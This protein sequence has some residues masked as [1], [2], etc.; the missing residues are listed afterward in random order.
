[1]AKGSAMTT[2]AQPRS[3]SSANA[4]PGRRRLLR[5]GAVAGA[6]AAAG[7]VWVL[8]VPVAGV[9]LAVRMGEQVQDVGLGAIVGTALA[10][11]LLGW[12]LLAVLESRSRR[13]V[14][15]WTAVALAVLVL[16]LAGPLTSAV[17]G[18]AA[19]VLVALHLA[20]AGML[21]PALRRTARVR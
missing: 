14:G 15:V 1:M 21:I 4:G 2:T 3:S 8:A 20:V 17:T 7:L 9:D 12:A 5:A 19:A 6:A 13:A 11:G 18:A 10:A 16:S